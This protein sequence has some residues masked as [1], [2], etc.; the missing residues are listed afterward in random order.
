MNRPANITLLLISMFTMSATFNSSASANHQRFNVNYDLV[1]EHSHDLEYIAEELKECIGDQ[2]RNAKYYGKLRSKAG[3]IKHRAHK[4]YRFG[5]DR[6]NCR[7]DNEINR[8]DRL[9]C[10]LSD[11]FD[12]SVAYSRHGYD[13]PI[14]GSAE[15]RVRKLIRKA[16][17]QISCLKDSYHLVKQ[18][19]SKPVY[20]EPSYSPVVYQQKV[21]HPVQ[22]VGGKYGV[23]RSGKNYGKHAVKKSYAN[24]RRPPSYKPHAKSKKLYG[25]GGGYHGRDKS[26]VLQAGGF[27]IQFNR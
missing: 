15:R 23:P 19:V 7:W 20:V 18:H 27:K 8:L 14:H 6:G 17:H 9:V 21:H 26:I 4:L 2:F 1:I 25:H 5:V 3:T 12:A 11:I 16:S 10:D 13:Q 22:N 24:N